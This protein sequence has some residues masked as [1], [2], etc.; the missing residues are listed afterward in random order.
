MTLGSVVASLKATCSGVLRPSVAAFALERH[1]AQK[2]VGNT[3][4]R[5]TALA[6]GHRCRA[7]SPN[8]GV[9]GTRLETGDFIPFR[10][11]VGPGRSTSSDGRAP[12]ASRWAHP[13]PSC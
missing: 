1:V 7:S 8:N 9:E 4:W 13:P 5:R 3:N 12:H 2:N 11:C 10:T 6:G